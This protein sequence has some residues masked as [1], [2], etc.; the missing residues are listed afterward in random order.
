MAYRGPENREGGIPTP[1]HG[2]I[3]TRFR[4]HIIP[5][6]VIKS[7]KSDN[8]T[9]WVL[10]G[11]SH[12]DREKQVI[13]KFKDPMTHDDASQLVAALNTA[14]EHLPSRYRSKHKYKVIGVPQKTKNKGKKYFA[15]VD[16]QMA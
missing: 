9:L 4:Y 3:N 14:N 8:E 1:H 5:S 2:V 16:E 7:W 13:K 6:D 15:L 10:W 11:E 12:N